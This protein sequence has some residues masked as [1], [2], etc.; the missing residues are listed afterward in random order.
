MS[1]PNHHPVTVIVQSVYGLVAE[2]DPGHRLSLVPD[3]D[4]GV[5]L[6]ELMCTHPLLPDGGCLVL[7]LFDLQP[8]DEVNVWCAGEMPDAAERT[9][10]WVSPGDGDDPWSWAIV[11]DPDYW[12]GEA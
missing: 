9:P 6:V 3:G 1:C 2:F 11:I 12:Q 4:H 10:V 8:L 5:P 7:A